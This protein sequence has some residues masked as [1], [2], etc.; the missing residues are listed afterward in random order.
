ME[1][2]LKSSRAQ[3]PIPSPNNV[4]FTDFSTLIESWSRTHDTEAIIELWP[5]REMFNEYTVGVDHDLQDRRTPPPP[6]NPNAVNPVLIG[7]NPA[8]VQPQAD[9]RFLRQEGIVSG[10][11]LRIVFGDNMIGSPGA[12]TLLEQ[13]DVLL[14][15]N[16]LAFLD[17]LH[18]YP[19]RQ[20]LPI[21]RTGKFVPVS[22]GQE[23]VVPVERLR[24][25]ALSVTPDQNVL[26][27]NSPSGNYRGVP[28]THL[29]EGIFALKLWYQL[30][31]RKRKEL[32]RKLDTS[33]DVTVAGIDL[34]PRTLEEIER[35]MKHR[36][37]YS[38]EV[39]L[40]NYLQVLRN[41]KLQI[42][43]SIYSRDSQN[44]GP[45]YPH[46]NLSFI[47]GTNNQSI[48]IDVDLSEEHQK[49]KQGKV[50]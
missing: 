26:W 18:S 48:S 20:F 12:W 37:G 32:L 24:D 29:A 8:P 39:W 11:S 46:Y 25:Y 3:K 36:Y 2:F 50:K 40:S 19:L 43:L 30:P 22:G 47:S 44:P 34:P 7:L 38:A 49:A 33:H 45:L 17:R 15:T 10:V 31:E 16:R 13:D 35:V 5:Q 9:Q 6:P 41:G 23:Y 28:I 21:A 4:Y 27:R 42:S 1:T 14:V